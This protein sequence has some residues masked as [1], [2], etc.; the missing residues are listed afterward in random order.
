VSAE[1]NNYLEDPLSTKFSEESFT[2]PT[3][4]MELQLFIL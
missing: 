3:S 4:R 1:L 2:N